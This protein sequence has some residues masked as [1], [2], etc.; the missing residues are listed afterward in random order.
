MWTRGASALLLFL[1]L[2]VLLLLQ[3]TFCRA[4]VSRVHDVSHKQ[5]LTRERAMKLSLAERL[6]LIARSLLMHQQWYDLDAGIPATLLAANPPNLDVSQTNQ[7]NTRK[8]S[9]KKTGAQLGA[10]NGALEASDQAE[11]AQILP[12]EVG[13]RWLDAAKAGDLGQLQETLRAQ[14]EDNRRDAT[15]VLGSQG[16]GT[17]YSFTGNTALHWASA[18]GH[19]DCV[20]WLLADGSKAGL[21]LVSC[22]NHSGA[23]P[24]HSAAANGQAAAAMLLLEAGADPALQDDCD[25]TPL[26]VRTHVQQPVDLAI[27]S[28]VYVASRG[29]R[30]CGM[31]VRCHTPTLSRLRS[32]LADK[33]S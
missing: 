13:K 9:H 33:K 25:E 3:V 12:R 26:E 17:S 8:Y 10:V 31:L 11:T 21:E 16:K 22:T 2:L 19:L 30:V 29:A 27:I 32:D 20:A 4:D 14:I 23:T 7:D 6:S 28:Q 18:K 24:L 1:F 5:L 15:T